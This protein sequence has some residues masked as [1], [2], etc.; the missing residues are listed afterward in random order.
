M[1]TK[2]DREKELEEALEHL[3]TRFGECSCGTH[4]VFII[5]ELAEDP[6]GGLRFAVQRF[7]PK[8]CPINGTDII[9]N[10]LP[11]RLTSS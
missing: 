2:T 9:V 3:C 10:D 6:P 8:I 5:D 11:I 4:Q 7:W 1:A